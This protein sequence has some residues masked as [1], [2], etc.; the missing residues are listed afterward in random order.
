MYITQGSQFYQLNY[1]IQDSSV[2][3]TFEKCD[4]YQDKSIF[5]YQNRF[6][7]YF[8]KVSNF[9]EE[10]T[11]AGSKINFPDKEVRLIVVLNYE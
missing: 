7:D 2:G 1:N 9:L 10:Q 11:L 5:K 6:Q 8:D 3:P 4:R